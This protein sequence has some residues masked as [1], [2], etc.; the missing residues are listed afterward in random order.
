MPRKTNYSFTRVPNFF[1]D[2]VLPSINNL[3]ELKVTLAIIR[4][5]T[6]WHQ[7]TKTITLSEL[8]TLTGLSRQS[9]IDGLNRA[10]ENGL[11]DRSPIRK[12]N[13][14]DSFVYSYKGGYMAQKMN[15]PKDHGTRQ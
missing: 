8:Q 3:A 7:S 1:L 15:A 12:K 6:G 14:R 11:I 9:A 13:G 2:E 10:L 5:T 4:K